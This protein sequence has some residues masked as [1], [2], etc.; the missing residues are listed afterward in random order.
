MSCNRREHFK[1]N[2]LCTHEE[3]K[4]ISI[5]T[6]VEPSQVHMGEMECSPSGAGPTGEALK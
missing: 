1:I 3:C 2:S 5:H 6:G 4:Y